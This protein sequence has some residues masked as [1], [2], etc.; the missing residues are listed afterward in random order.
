MA[1]GFSR[2]GLSAVSI[3]LKTATEDTDMP[4]NELL[5][6]RPSLPGR[7]AALAVM[8]SLPLSTL[9]AQ[10]SRIANAIG[11]GRKVPLEGALH[12]KALR[13]HDQGP[14]DPSLN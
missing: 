8:V 13:E 12:P 9:S 7:L 11:P 1:P 2:T 5:K 3:A 14:V 6:T 4:R 10:H